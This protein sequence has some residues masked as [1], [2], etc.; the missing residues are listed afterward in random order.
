MSVNNLLEVLDN[1]T[2]EL[3]G[4]IAEGK[5][6][7]DRIFQLEQ[8]INT[9]QNAPFDFYSLDSDAVDFVASELEIDEKYLERMSKCKDIY[10]IWLQFGSNAVPQISMVESFIEELKQHL[11]EKKLALVDKATEDQYNISRYNELCHLSERLKDPNQPTLLTPLLEEKMNDMTLQDKIAAKKEMIAKNNGIYSKMLPI[12]L[13]TTSDDYDEQIEELQTQLEEEFNPNTLKQ[14]NAVSDLLASCQSQEEINSIID[15]WWG[16]FDYEYQGK[17]IAGLIKLKK[18]D[19]LVI[20]SV[21]SKN[22]VNYQD[23]IEKIN[24]QISALEEFDEALK[25]SADLEENAVETEL[26]GLFSDSKVDYY[27]NKYEEDPMA[28]PNCVLFLNDGIERDIRSIPD[29]ETLEDIFI[30]IEQLKDDQANLKSFTSNKNLKSIYSLRPNSSGRQARVICAKLDDNIYGV[31]CVY[32]KK[33]NNPKHLHNLIESRR[34]NCDLDG[35]KSKIK[36]EE[37]LSYYCEKTKQI[38]KTLKENV[39]GKGNVVSG[40]AK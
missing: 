14:L 25:E 29:K 3:N 24:M 27:L 26:P 20:K 17:I 5:S 9:L 19:L 18:V 31:I 6:R 36:D 7:I 10:Q 22:M 30:L 4:K 39:S 37:N 35:L 23:D 2:S 16:T 40:G 21:T 15:K 32:A 13:V 28:S 8:I 1:E 11:E 38:S 12:D 33:A 34:K